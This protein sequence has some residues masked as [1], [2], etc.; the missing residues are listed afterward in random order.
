MATLKRTDQT[1]LPNVEVFDLEL[2][3]DELSDLYADPEKYLRDLLDREGHQVNRLLIDTRV[4]AGD[5]GCGIK[6]VHSLADDW[7]KSSHVIA[8]EKCL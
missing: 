8:C 6:V 7:T 4:N 2:S 3:E 5:C 1:E